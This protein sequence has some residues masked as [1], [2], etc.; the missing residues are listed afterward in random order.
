M[1]YHSLRVNAPALY[2]ASLNAPTGTRLLVMILFERTMAGKP[3]TP[4]QAKIASMMHRSSRTVRRWLTIGV[5]RGWI[6][7][8]RRGKTQTN[9]Y[10][11]SRVLWGRLTGQRPSTLPRELQASL[12]RLGLKSG[13]AVGEM[14]RRGVVAR[15]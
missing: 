8:I 12:F 15:R 1:S 7:V 13:L 11:L 10:M 4:S 5:K 2:A 6:R 9:R 3:F 14:S